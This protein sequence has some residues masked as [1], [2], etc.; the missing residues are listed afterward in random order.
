MATITVG[1]ATTTSL[2]GVTFSRGLDMTDT[3]VASISEAI[4][5]DLNNTLP[6]WPGA[7][8]RTGL[9]YIPNRGI[10]QVLPGDVVAVD[11]STG[12]PVLVSKRAIAGAVWSP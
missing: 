8:A 1:T 7:F 2:L 10:L 11:Q 6:F 5:N 3:D 12:W 9:L 4:K